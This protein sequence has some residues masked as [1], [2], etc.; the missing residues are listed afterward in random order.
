[1]RESIRL[2]LEDGLPCIAECG[3]FMYLTEGIEGMPMVGLIKG[4]CFDAGRL[5]R[6]G[7]ITLTA[8]EDNLLC[9]KGAAIP[10]HEFHRWDADNTGTAFTAGKLDGRQWPCVHASKTLYA[11][12]PHFHFFADLSFAESFYSACLGR[13]NG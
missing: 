3:G 5:Q 12:F 13:K 9:K 10:A 2:A 6:F 4:N 11:G 8:N 1:M 7:C